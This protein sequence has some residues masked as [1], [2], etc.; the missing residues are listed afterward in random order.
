M[1]DAQLIFSLNA[2][3]HSFL[4]IPTPNQTNSR[5]QIDTRSFT[6][7]DVVDIEQDLYLCYHSKRYI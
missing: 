5:K 6:G 7:D 3:D 4:L 2:F 1:P